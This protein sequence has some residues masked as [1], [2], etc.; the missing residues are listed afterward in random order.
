M[1]MREKW[2]EGELQQRKL[3]NETW[4]NNGAVESEKATGQRQSFLFFPLHLGPA[5]APGGR[6][7]QKQLVI[8]ESGE[9]TGIDPVLVVRDWEKILGG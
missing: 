2:R 9:G 3:F 5:V 6:G 1:G 7:C 4:F 8:L